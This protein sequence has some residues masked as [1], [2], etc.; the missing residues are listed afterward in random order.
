MA[1]SV[2]TW[3]GDVRRARRVSP[4]V[5]VAILGVL[6]LWLR[7]TSGSASWQEF[8][9]SSIVAGI[10]VA[11]VALAV[12]PRFFCPG[13]NKH[14]ATSM[15]WVC[16]YCDS[17]NGGL[18]RTFLDSCSTCGRAPAIVI[19]PHPHRSG[20]GE[21]EVFPIALIET[22][23]ATPH[24]ARKLTPQQPGETIEQAKARWVR[25][26]QLVEAEMLAAG[27]AA[28]RSL[29]SA[30]RQDI[31]AER[32]LQQ[33]MQAPRSVTAE[34]EQK[35]RRVLDGVLARFKGISAT[36]PEIHREYDT[37]CRAIDEIPGL[38]VAAKERL[39]GDLSVR[40]EDAISRLSE[41]A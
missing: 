6:F 31:G 9:A 14:I 30:K 4:L 39:K 28:K 19:C 3:K 16:G 29:A 33:A 10:V 36:I 13:C 37:A 38:P 41:Q 18:F 22:D 7:P 32:E 27:A 2:V 40:M 15:E 23:E 17:P 20:G 21:I 12:R 5:L 24:P 35:G 34:A 11:L 25:E 26:R 8:I 1:Q